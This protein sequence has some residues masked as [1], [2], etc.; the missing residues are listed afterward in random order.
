MT[1]TT[2]T[3]AE[4]AAAMH[5]AVTATITRSAHDLVALSRTIHDHPEV[6]FEE[7]VSAQAVADLLRR[8]GHE[9]TVG[10]HGMATALLARAGE[11]GPTVAI[12]AEY[13]ALPE[14]GHGC[15]HNVICAAAVGAFLGVA[16]VLD[17]TGGS[18]VLLGTPAEEN[19]GGKE[20]LARAGAFEGIDAA[21]MVHP[22]SGAH[23]VAH[24]ESLGC[25]SVA[26]TYHGQSAHASAAPHLGRNALDATVAAY[27]GIA[28]LRQHIPATDRLHGVI[29]DGGLSPN[30]VPD[31][32]ASVWLVRART[33]EGLSQLCRRAEEVF[34]AA[35]Q[36]TGTEAEIGWD[37]G[38]AY[39]PVRGNNPLDQRYAAHARGRGRMLADDLDE[40][41]PPGGSTDLGNISVRIPAIHPTVAI[42][43]PEVPMHSVEFAAHACSPEAD[44]AVIDAAMAMALTAADYLHDPELRAQ[45]ASDFAAAG[46]F[47]DVPT[48]LDT[49]KGDP[50]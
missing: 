33:V 5:S 44:R 26:V 12:L 32:S 24:F 10:L 4:G 39:L 42:A 38:P 50:S 13:D 22:M 21:L 35:A 46:G 11:G 9:V 20:T 31:H 25:R 48:V 16:G 34:R 1:S 37:V 18:V 47:V 15:G 40:P 36:M 7:H 27:Q 45:C 3:R 29:T 14:V 30:V 28:A 17:R 8:R 2:T 23:D 19:G 41:A 49:D 6:G 43:P